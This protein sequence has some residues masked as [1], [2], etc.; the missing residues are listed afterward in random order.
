MRSA[1][2]SV[3]AAALLLLA[4]PADAQR[5]SIR[6]MR[7]VSDG[8]NL[9]KR[10]QRPIMFLV[11]GDSRRRDETVNLQRQKSMA[12][13]RVLY[14]ARRFVPIKIVRSNSRYR[15]LFKKLGV[16]E[17]INMEAV[18]STPGGKQLGSHHAIHV[19]DT[20]SQKMTQVF[21]VYRKQLFEDK[22]REQLEAEKPKTKNLRN[23]L[24]LVEEFTI[25]EAEEPVLKL[26]DNKKLNPAVAKQA[27]AALAELSTKAAVEFLLKHAADAAS[28]HRKIAADALGKCTPVAAEL[29]VAELAGKDFKRALAAYKAAAKIC[30][31]KKPKGD[32]FWRGDNARVKRDEV[33]RVKRIVEKAAHRWR[34]RY[35]EYR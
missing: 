18:F 26:F 34:E 23:A 29:L 20:F 28:P 11:V 13:P 25:F 16:R 17:D 12:D 5:K 24:K 31:I 33:E 15:A 30:R 21:R 10:S 19:P 9:A 32:R 1:K 14:A 35:E 4:V 6:W 27:V 2:M 3:V 22:L 7:D 8:I